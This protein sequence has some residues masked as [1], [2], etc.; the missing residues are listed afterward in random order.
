MSN[1]WL[2][3]EAGDHP[4]EASNTPA[5]ELLRGE[6]R[7]GREFVVGCE[8]WRGFQ[9]QWG[10]HCCVHSSEKGTGCR[11]DELPGPR[12]RDRAARLWQGTGR[13]A[14]SHGKHPRGKAGGQARQSL[15]PYPTVGPSDP[16]DTHEGFDDPPRQPR[17]SV[18]DPRLYLI[19]TKSDASRTSRPYCTRTAWEHRRLRAVELTASVRNTLDW[20]FTTSEALQGTTPSRLSPCQRRLS[21]S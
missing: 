14:A 3:P 7:C 10:G 5:F 12:C 16:R 18:I 6:N 11:S 21:E 8:P 15:S 20:R 1:T 9:Y 13:S 17:P 19:S 4:R 2:P